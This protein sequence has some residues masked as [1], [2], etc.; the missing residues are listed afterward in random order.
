M[1]GASAKVTIVIPPLIASSATWAR[2][3]IGIHTAASSS[4]P[5]TMSAALDGTARARRD[6]APR[7]SQR[8]DHHASA[9]PIDMLASVPSA[10]SRP[11]VTP[12]KPR[13]C[14]K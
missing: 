3:G 8:C 10:N 5:P 9:R 13:P 12:S 6:V 11:A 14:C 1:A 4:A 2:L 7:P